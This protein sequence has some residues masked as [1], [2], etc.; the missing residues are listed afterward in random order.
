MFKA[1]QKQKP[2]KVFKSD[3]QRWHC[4]YV[5]VYVI[6]GLTGTSV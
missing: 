1:R 4:H 6:K 2:D 5:L 3:S